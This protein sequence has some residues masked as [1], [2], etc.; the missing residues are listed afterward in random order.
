V[1][2]KVEEE[3]EGVSPG[4]ESINLKISKKIKSSFVSNIQK[5]FSNTSISI[6]PKE[7]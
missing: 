4:R 3:R 5:N 2:L 1:K 7:K 6:D